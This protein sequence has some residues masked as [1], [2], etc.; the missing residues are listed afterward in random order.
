M[1]RSGIAGYRFDDVMIWDHADDVTGT[2]DHVEHNRAAWDRW[3]GEY[4]GSGLTHLG[5]NRAELG[6]LEYPRG[7][8]GRAAR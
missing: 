1:P 8:G 6:H 2:A 5:G 7:D 3:A 4:C